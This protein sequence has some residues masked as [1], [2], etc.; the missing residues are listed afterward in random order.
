MAICTVRETPNHTLEF[1]E[2]QQ[3][4]G[5]KWDGNKVFYSLEYDNECPLISTRK[6]RKAINLAMS[7]WN[8]EIP[9]KIKSL[10]RNYDNAD[11]KI[12]FR[13]K[14]DDD[15]FRERDGVLAY[16]YF[17][18][19]SK[20]GQ[21]VFNIDKIWS[22][23]GEGVKAS[24]AIRLGIIDNAS[25]PNSTIRTYNIIHT[26]IHEIGHSLGLRH[27]AD[28]NTTDVMDPYYDG[29]VLDLSSR[30]LY[31]IRLKYGTRVWRSWSM[32]DRIKK[33]LYNKKRNI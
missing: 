33:W 17:P 8:F 31:R 6:M 14:D 1:S 30:D 22:V 16:A 28:D 24:E 7:T 5:H 9:I 12:M 11:I 23:D 29:K 13:K 18:K 15:I 21:I 19:T 4:W 25:N 26:L 27:D 2:D 10:Y 3:E 20:Q 32:Y